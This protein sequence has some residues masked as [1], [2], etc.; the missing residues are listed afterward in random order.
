VLLLS[1]IFTNVLH[2]QDI[3]FSQYFNS[4]LS[5][6]P[7]QTGN[8]EGD[9]RAYV[10]YRDQWRAIAYPFKTFSFGYDR[11]LQLQK[12]D[13]GIGAYA[14][15]D[16]SG[17]FLNCT[18]FYLSGSYR[19]M[20]NENNFSGGLQVG[21]VM[22]SVNYDKIAFPDDYNV[23]INAFDPNFNQT[24]NGK[25]QLSYLDVNLGVGWSRKINKYEP[26][27]GFS[28]F[29]INQ[30]SESFEGNANATKLAMRSAFFASVKTELN[31]NLY[32]KPG[33]LLYMMRGSR[34]MMIGSQAGYTLPGNRF[35][36]KEVYGGLY[37]RN[38]L[39]DP[40][41]AIVI[42]FGAQVRKVAINVSYDLSISS[43]RV[44]NNYRGA[45]ELSIIFKSITT[46]IKTFTIP[47]ERI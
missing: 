13:I 23:A 41:D 34:D 2:G 46:I 11:K 9:W 40:T 45:F 47:C 21:Y 20:I 29:H 19:K 39:A 14:F 6:N 43:M 31:P 17:I 35:N 30:P 42:M 26:E 1:I 15:N 27:I 16:K 36:V 32:L 5:L 28:F 3:H 7:S 24:D 22:K 44:Y 10:N 25:S 12:H 8:F 33:M 37:L 4:P 18:E 38:G